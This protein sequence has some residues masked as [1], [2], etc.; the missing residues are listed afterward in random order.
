M[1]KLVP[2]LFAAGTINASG[3]VMDG[4]FTGA[5]A[6]LVSTIVV[7]IAVVK[8]IDDR[9]ENKLRIY[10]RINLHNQ[11]LILREVSETR[12]LMG[13]DPLPNDLLEDPFRQSIVKE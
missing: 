1:R 3:F 7:T 6:A 8:W 13:K 10:Q 2:A 9:I 4:N 11:R 12:K 5:I